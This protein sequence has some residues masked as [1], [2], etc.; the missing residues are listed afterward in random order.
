MR[1]THDD[2]HRYRGTW[3]DGDRRRIAVYARG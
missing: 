3:R 1:K 2:T